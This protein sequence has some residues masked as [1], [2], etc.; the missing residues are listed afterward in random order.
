M[1]ELGLGEQFDDSPKRWRLP[2]F[3][4]DLW[5]GVIRPD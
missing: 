5:P 3:A 4:N 2:D 1:G